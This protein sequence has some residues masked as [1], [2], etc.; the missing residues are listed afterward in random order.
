MD[1]ECRCNTAKL[2]KKIPQHK[3]A[4]TLVLTTK[5]TK[6]LKL[7]MPLTANQYNRLQLTNCFVH[8]RSENTVK[9]PSHFPRTSSNVLKFIFN[10]SIADIQFTINLRYRESQQIFTL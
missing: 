6:Y 9:Y 1:C 5:Y 4:K 3:V 2:L 10:I 7:I 8:K